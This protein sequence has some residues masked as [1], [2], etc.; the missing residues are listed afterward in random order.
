VQ[1]VAPA[2]LYDPAAQMVQVVVFA[3]Y[4]P[5]AQFPTWHK[6]LTLFADQDA[7]AHV[8]RLAIAEQSV[9]VPAFPVPVPAVVFPFPHA[10]QP[11]DAVVAFDREPT[12]QAVHAVPP[13]APDTL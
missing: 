12:A 9:Q 7:V 5:A 8:D 10:V 4:D 13:A 3:L 11:V 1:D 6:P 2:L